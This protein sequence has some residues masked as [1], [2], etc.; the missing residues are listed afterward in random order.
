M[1]NKSI[2]VHIWSIFVFKTACAC[3]A[4]NSYNLVW[5]FDKIDN[6]NNLKL[7]AIFFYIS[8]FDISNFIIFS[9]WDHIE[10]L[11]IH[12]IYTRY[13]SLGIHLIDFKRNRSYKVYQFLNKEGHVKD[14]KPSK[15]LTFKKSLSFIRSKIFFARLLVE[16]KCLTN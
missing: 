9:I 14:I 2:Y 8:N 11:D 10:L 3:Q 13:T 1:F 16:I 4:C 15:K 7:N 6:F 5:C 12:P